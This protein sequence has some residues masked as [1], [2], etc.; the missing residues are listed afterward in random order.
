MTKPIELRRQSVAELEER[1]KTLKRQ[2]FTFK[3]QHGQGQLAKP[4]Q[5][6]QARRDVA[7][8]LTIISE[9]RR[10]EKS[11]AAGGKA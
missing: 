6:R 9:K 4:A 2:L 7:R 10:A 5:I 8:I 1:V 3:V 11:A